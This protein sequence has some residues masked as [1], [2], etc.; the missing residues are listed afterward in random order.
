MFGF[1]NKPDDPESDFVESLNALVRD[2]KKAGVARRTIMNN[3]H[4]H[5]ESI[6]R[7][8]NAEIERRKMQC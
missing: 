7:M 2:A 6:D 3:L 5:A 4:E 8:L 1:K